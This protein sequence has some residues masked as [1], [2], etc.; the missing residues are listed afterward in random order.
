MHWNKS[1]WASK[2]GIFGGFI[3]LGTAKSE[4]LIVIAAQHCNALVGKYAWQEKAIYQYIYNMSL[5]F[6]S[7]QVRVIV[8]QPQLLERDDLSF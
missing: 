7:G 2:W 4:I 1:N 6:P 3:E 5:G 8:G